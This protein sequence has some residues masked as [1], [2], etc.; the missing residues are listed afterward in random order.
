MKPWLERAV[1]WAVP[2]PA[3]RW[4]RKRSYVRRLRRGGGFEGEMRWLPGLISPGD[5]VLDIGANAGFYAARLA[6]LVG[7]QGAVHAFEPIPET[8]DI[9]RHVVAALGLTNVVL[10]PAA[11]ADREGELT[12]EVPREGRKVENYYLAHLTLAPAGGQRA[13]RGRTRTLDALR[14][15]GLPRVS[16]VKCDVEGAEL[17]V[18]RG[19]AGLLRADLPVLLCEVSDAM[20]TRLGHTSDEVFAFLRELGYDAWYAAGD[21]LEPAAG[22]VPGV[23]NYFFIPRGRPLPVPQ[24]G[25]PKA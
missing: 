13:V 23:V 10:Y 8:F 14:A 16:F 1:L 21:R 22:T 18:L 7:P 15:A 20:A 11:V 17:L 6:R 3:R 12:M 24:W 25:S 2:A 5:T 4:L 19:G 9:L